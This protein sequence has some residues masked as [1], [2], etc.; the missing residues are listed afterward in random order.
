MTTQNSKRNELKQRDVSTGHWK[1]LELCFN[2]GFAVILTTVLTAFAKDRFV[3][4]WPVDLSPSYCSKFLGVILLI[5]IIVL[6]FLWTFAVWNEMNIL[7]KYFFKYIP[8]QP[9]QVAVWTVMFCLVLGLLGKFSDRIVVCSAIFAIYGLGDI[10]GQKIRNNQLKDVLRKMGKDKYE[11]TPTQVI[12]S[13]YL[14][15]PQLERSAS[16]MFFSF[17]GLMLAQASLFN[18][19]TLKGKWLECSAYLVVILNIAIGEI[20]IYRWRR[21]RDKILKQYDNEHVQNE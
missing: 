6:L 21:Q 15:R 17:V 5:E 3:S 8:Q 1:K 13:F 16:I 9:Y 7:K 14:E 2:I 18:E 20:V 4:L 19:S 11:E 12:K 10:W